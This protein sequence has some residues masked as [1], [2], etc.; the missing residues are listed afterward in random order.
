MPRETN[1]R[2]K[3]LAFGIVILTS[4][5]FG[6]GLASVHDSAPAI[7]ATVQQANYNATLNVTVTDDVHRPIASANVRI[8]G[9]STMNWQTNSTGQVQITGLLADPFPTGTEYT[10][11]A[12]RTGYKPTNQTIVAF[13][14]QSTD[15]TLVIEG[16]KILGT[17]VSA[18][19]PSVPIV[20]ANVTISALG[21]WTLAASPDGSYE[22][23]GLPAGT[24]SVTAT[25]VGYVLRSQDIKISIGGSVL[26]N[27]V[28][29]SQN[30]SISGFVFHQKLHTPLANASVSVNVGIFE[31][32]VKSG[33]DGSYNITSLPAGL[34]EVAASTDGFFPSVMSDVVVTRGNK[35][36]NVNFSLSE[37]PTRLH[38]IV[39]S[40]SFLLNEVNISVQGTSFRD[41]TD[42]NGT[43][44][45]RNI[46]AGTYNVTASRAGYLSTTFKVIILPGG[47]TERNVNLTA[48][49]GAVL[50]GYVL[51]SD[52]NSP[53]MN[54]KVSIVSSDLVQKTEYTT[55]DGGF[56]FTELAPGNYTLQFE[57][58]DYRPMIV[59]HVV[60]TDGDTPTRNYTMTPLRHGFSGF[61][62]GFDMSHS[63]MFLAL[64]LTILILGVAV[65][66]RARTFQAPGN[67]PAI[68]DE[69]EN[70]GEV[71]PEEEG[72]ISEAGGSDEGE[73]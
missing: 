26:G 21:Y 39:R 5:A 52:T 13:T 20:G 23:D 11:S 42:N 69:G 73:S 15:V 63:M 31:I 36:A 37:K 71:T 41:T 45:I 62:F 60:V 57:R 8:V 49:P 58:T 38:G 9:N 53:L 2:C 56:K 65:Y 48:L 29:I 7:K 72:P 17:V 43:Y 34:Y 51:A 50:R 47:D 40:E 68:Y 35:T 54:V 10:L 22:L 28:L 4:A 44:E 27:F 70:E 59:G 25:A 1:F 64:C 18:S 67:A 24:L 19:V 33:Q 12:A 30:G 55:V 6:L 61:L 66:L 32:R 46:T 14:N 3:L 16:G